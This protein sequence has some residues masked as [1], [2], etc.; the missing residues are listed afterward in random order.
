MNEFNPATDGPSIQDLFPDY[1][2]PE[3][4]EFDTTEDAVA[5][6]AIHPEG[7]PLTTVE[8]KTLIATRSREIDQPLDMLQMLWE[9]DIERMPEGSEREELKT[10]YDDRAMEL[11]A[12]KIID[13]ETEPGKTE[14]PNPHYR[15]EAR[16]GAISMAIR[17][18]PFARVEAM[19]KMFELVDKKKK[20]LGIETLLGP[21]GVTEV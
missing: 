3:N 13:L 18:F 2:F 8:L 1:P 12:T 5:Y 10:I 19:E 4:M 21:D 11:F 20:E 7:K 16:L 17:D 14:D 6:V 9:F 15:P